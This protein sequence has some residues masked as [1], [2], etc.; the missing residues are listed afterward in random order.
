[1]Y[2]IS[3]GEEWILYSGCMEYMVSDRHIFLKFGKNDRPH[4][5]VIFGDNSKG[6]ALGLGKVAIARDSSIKNVN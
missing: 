6:K 2:Y 1:M 3:G 5:Y 4:K